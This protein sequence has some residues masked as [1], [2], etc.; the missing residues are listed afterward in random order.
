[1]SACLEN[2][3]SLLRLLVLE[4][5]VEVDGLDRSLLRVVRVHVHRRA[6]VTGASARALTTLVRLLLLY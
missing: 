5:R 6:Q 3:Y 4:L 2:L 1:M